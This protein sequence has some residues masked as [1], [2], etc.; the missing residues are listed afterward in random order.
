MREV[1]P[2]RGPAAEGGVGVGVV[3]DGE[4]FVVGGGE[5][6]VGNAAGVGDGDHQLISALVQKS[7][8]SMP[9]FAR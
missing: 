1:V 4:R 3:E 7:T 2:R 8:T 5:L 6:E 9:S